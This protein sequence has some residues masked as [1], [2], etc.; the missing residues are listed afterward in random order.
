M[1]HVPAPTRPA[2][3]PENLLFH[4]LPPRGQSVVVRYGATAVILAV[5]I[6]FQFAL[7]NTVTNRPFLLFT[8]PVFLSALLF[9][10]GSGFLATA[11]AAIAANYFFIEP[12]HGFLPATTNDIV[13]TLLFLIIGAS[14]ATLTEALRKALQDVAQGERERAL[15]LKELNHRIRNDLQMVAALLKLSTRDGDPKQALDAAADRVHILSE[16]YDTLIA[17]DDTPQLDAQELMD[18]LAG[19]FRSR[20]MGMRPITITTE[21]ASLRIKTRCAT[22]LSLILNELVT[23]S[24]KHAFPDMR[25]GTIR[26]ELRQNESGLELLVADDGI[27]MPREPRQGFGTT[28]V[29][30]MAAQHGGAVRL[31]SN[32]GT[33]VTVAMPP[34]CVA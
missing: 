31:Q 26:I 33:T 21:I 3:S 8:L 24:L 1:D 6:V 12:K 17:R 16:V 18:T 9:N 34:G 20:I 7:S 27:G 32:G 5:F 23:N 2:L 14:I 29:R 25:P 4:L 28:L 13:G 19:A 30:Q 15:L 11:L 22:A 10:R